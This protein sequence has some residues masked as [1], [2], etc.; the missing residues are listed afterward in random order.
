MGRAQKTTHSLTLYFFTDSLIEC[1]CV[2]EKRKNVFIIKPSF[3]SP[4]STK[5]AMSST[6]CSKAPVCSQICF[7]SAFKGLLFS[8]EIA[9]VQMSHLLKTR[10][11]LKWWT[12][13]HASRIKKADISAAI[14]GWDCPLLTFTS[15]RVLSTWLKWFKGVCQ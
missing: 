10:V 5:V 9:L 4:A 12:Q 8:S 15:P 2:T 13:N 1:K 3:R 14:Y 6:G 7:V 11:I